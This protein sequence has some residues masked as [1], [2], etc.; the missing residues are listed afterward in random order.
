[1]RRD[2]RGLTGPLHPRELNPWVT[3]GALQAPGMRE[4]GGSPKAEA[5]LPGLCP[6]V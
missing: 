3:L 6:E 1:M 2:A 4:H 5:E